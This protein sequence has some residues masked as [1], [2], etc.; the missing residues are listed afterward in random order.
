MLA[1]LS[2]ESFTSTST[3]VEKIHALA[4][5]HELAVL[6][7][8]QMVYIIADPTP[9]LR[10][11]LPHLTKL[12]T[13]ELQF[14]YMF[15]GDLPV[16]PL[17]TRLN[18]GKC[19]VDDAGLENICRCFPNLEALSVEGTSI[20]NAGLCLLSDQL[21]DLNVSACAVTDLS[22]LCRLSRLTSLD[23]S[24]CEVERVDKLPKSLKTLKV[25]SCLKLDPN[26]LRKLR[27]RRVK[28]L[29]QNWSV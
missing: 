5:Q 13:L 16:C 21:R 27:R 4:N 14:W 19:S 24:L 25:T 15:A 2:L 28:I 23:L 7:L 26:S 9:A 8:E 3:P 10:E 12:H 6:H 20:T 29:E 11:L 22:S 18:V 17:I 1:H